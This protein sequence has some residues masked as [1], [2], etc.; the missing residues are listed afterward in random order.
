MTTGGTGSEMRR[1]ISAGCFIRIL[2]LKVNDRHTIR[3]KAASCSAPAPR[4]ERQPKVCRRT[5]SEMRNSTARHRQGFPVSRCNRYSVLIDAQPRG[6]NR[7]TVNRFYN[8]TVCVELFQTRCPVDTPPP[9]QLGDGAFFKT[10]VTDC[11]AKLRIGS[12]VRGYNKHVTF[13]PMIQST[14]D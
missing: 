9:A 11:T 10:V 7:Q 14:I 8:S 6:G 13:L 1:E 2:L 12:K 5:G 3:S 4:S